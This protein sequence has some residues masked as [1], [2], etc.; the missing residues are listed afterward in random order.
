MENSQR[1]WIMYI[2]FSLKFLTMKELTTESHFITWAANLIQNG[3]KV[4]TISKFLSK[5]MMLWRQSSF[6]FT[7]D[8]TMWISSILICYNGCAL[9]KCC[10]EHPQKIT[11]LNC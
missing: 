10:Y 3:Y 1:V 4:I 5:D 11:L 8:M 9:L 7:E 6:V 2:V